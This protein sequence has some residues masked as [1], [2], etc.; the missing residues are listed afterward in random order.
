MS[1]RTVLSGLAVLAVGV[2]GPIQGQESAIDRGSIIL[3]G[4]VGFSSIGGDQF[5]DRQNAIV[6]S[7][8]VQ[9]FVVPHLAVGGNVRLAYI[10]GSGA[11]IAQYGIGPRLGYYFGAPESRVYPF[12]AVTV[13]MDRVDFG[14][15]P[16]P[17][18]LAPDQTVL[19]FQPAAGAS[20]M[21]GDEV[22]ITGQL[23]Y[24]LTSNDV[25]GAASSVDT[26]E[27]GLDFGVTVFVF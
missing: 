3:G 24:R 22:A 23:F 1:S 11:S 13:A 10:S 9:F 6:I 7:P 5:A 4:Q 19:R 25:E 15:P 12:V 20:F 16:T 21:V 14:E 2:V 17:G 18:A 8:N 26:N 27:I